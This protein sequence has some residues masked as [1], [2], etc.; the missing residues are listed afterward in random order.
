MPGGARA[1]EERVRNMVKRLTMT[2]LSDNIA[3]EP[4]TAE[5]G[6]SILVE[7]DGRRIL[8]DTGGGQAFASNARLL[9]LDLSAVDTAVL[10]HAHY[11]HADGMETFFGINGKAPFLVREEAEENCFGLK[12]GQMTYIGI[13]RGTLATWAS[14]ITP[15]SGVYEIASGILL[16]PHREGDYSA[17]ARRGDLYTER[18]GEYLPDDFS[19]EQ[20]LVID[21]PRGA[22]IFNSCSHTG[23][24]NILRDVEELAGRREIQAYV[25]GLHLYKLTD[26]ELLVLC[27]QL[28]DS[29]VR[30]FYTGHCTGEHAFEV[31]RSELGDRICQFRAG[32]R[33]EF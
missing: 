19:H 16:V 4:L 33:Q 8:L 5:W 13:R 6:L 28:R 26:E 2:V 25:G 32:F 31:L 12:E 21:T 24:E 1:R 10:S 3:E 20:S 23:P 14:R 29:A 18:D 15:V 30:R 27:R 9:G 22:V 11:D 7:A 17:I